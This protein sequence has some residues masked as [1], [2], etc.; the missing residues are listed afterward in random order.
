FH[1]SDP[2]ARNDAMRA[3]LAPGRIYYVEIAPNVAGVSILA[4]TPRQESWNEVADWIASTR[5]LVP[6]RPAGQA[7]L[8]ED[9]GDVK[10]EIDHA[11]DHLRDDDDEDLRERTIVASDGV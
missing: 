6:D 8:D 7:H 1:A 11:L 10:D 9:A 2:I 3:T 5:E 4:I